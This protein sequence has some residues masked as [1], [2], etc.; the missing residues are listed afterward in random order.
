MQVCTSLQTDNHAS[1]P[2]L[3][4]LQAGCS[5]CRPTNSIK[6]TKAQTGSAKWHQNTLVFCDHTN[7][8]LD[9][10]FQPFLKQQTSTGVA[11]H[12][13]V[14]IVKF[15]SRRFFKPQKLQ[16]GACTKHAAQMA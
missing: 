11:M 8:L 12:V 2:P 14:K 15:L 10:L 7:S 3:S 6:A 5:S 9:V 4:F 16:W 13:P 1:T